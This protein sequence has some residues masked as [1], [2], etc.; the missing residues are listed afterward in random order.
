MIKV[1][2][3]FSRKADVYDA[4]GEAHPNLSRMRQKVRQNMLAHLRTGDRILELNAG[5]GADAAFFAS[6]GFNVLATDVSPGMVA[7]IEQKRASQGLESRLTV[8]QCSFDSLE[9]LEGRSFDFVFSNMGG[10]NCTADLDRVAGGV[11]KLLK[12]GGRV[13]WVIMPPICLWELA[14]TL[15]GDLSTALRRLSPGGTLAHVEGM[16]FMTWYHTPRRVVRAFGNHFHLTQLVGLSVF[17]PP[18]DHKFFPT[19][20]PRWYVWLQ[21]L[22]DLLADHYPFNHWGDFY[23]L[24]LEKHQP[25]TY[26]DTG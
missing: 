20:H 13:T 17:T 6:L 3:A 14:Q 19:R 12:P 25:S 23:I 26:S 1:A 8:Q 24:T 16:H 21:W 9:Q 18:A 5:T 15:R 7:A 22:D 2:E 11:D 10:I 4:F